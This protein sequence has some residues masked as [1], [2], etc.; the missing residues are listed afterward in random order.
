VKGY[1]SEQEQIQTVQV[2]APSLSFP[3]DCFMT[4]ILRMETGSNET[5]CFIKLAIRNDHLEM[6]GHYSSDKQDIKRRSVLFYKNSI[7]MHS[8]FLLRRS[9]VENM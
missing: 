1:K 4:I 3:T 7:S 6:N 9:V 5:D 2:E 8:A